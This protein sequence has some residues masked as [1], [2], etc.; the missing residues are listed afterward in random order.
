MKFAIMILIDCDDED[1][2]HG[3]AASIVDKVAPEGSDKH[4]LRPRVHEV[5]D[6]RD[7][8]TMRGRRGERT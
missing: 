8:I 3:F 6:V 1:F 2:A 5:L 7:E 4:P